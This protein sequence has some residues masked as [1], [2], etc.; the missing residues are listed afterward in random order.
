M[1]I[2]TLRFSLHDSCILFALHSIVYNTIPLFMLHIYKTSSDTRHL[3][4][5]LEASASREYLPV[6]HTQRI[7]I[8]VRM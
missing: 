7:A 5:I 6:L 4:Y 8:E 2:V 1:T 3:A